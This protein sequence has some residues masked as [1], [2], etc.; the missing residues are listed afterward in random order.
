[1]FRIVGAANTVAAIATVAGLNASRSNAL[2]QSTIE[3]AASLFLLGILSFILSFALLHVTRVEAVHSFYAKRSQA[4]RYSGKFRGGT[5]VYFASA[6]L[7]GSVSVI[8]FIA[9]VAALIV[10]P[11]TDSLSPG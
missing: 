1:V 7:A 4:N 9:G 5:Y 11:S 3:T 2:I 10:T 6:A 8:L